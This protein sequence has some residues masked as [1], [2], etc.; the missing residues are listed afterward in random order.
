MQFNQAISITMPYSLVV[1]MV[2]DFLQAAEGG[3]VDEKLIGS[4]AGILAG[5]MSLASVRF[6]PRFQTMQCC[7]CMRDC[8]FIQDSMLRMHERF[9]E[10]FSPYGRVLEQQRR[11][12]TSRGMGG[13]RFST[14]LDVAQ[15]HSLC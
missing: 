6:Q 12:L 10:P 4:R 11:G 7:A 13:F 8:W 2:R 9:S 15:C 3:P 5:A 14:A 1:Y